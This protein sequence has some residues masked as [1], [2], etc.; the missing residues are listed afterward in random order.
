VCTEGAPEMIDQTAREE[1]L[2]AKVLPASRPSRRPPARGVALDRGVFVRPIAHR[3][4]HNKSRGLIENTAPAFLAAIDQDYG[5][6]CDLQPAR[7]GTPMVFHD[8]TLDRLIRGRGRIAAHTPDELSRLRYKDQDIA[9]LSFQDLLKLVAG[10]VPLLVEIKSNGR[11]PKRFLAAIAEGA[12]GYQGPIALMSFDRAVVTQLSRL[13]PDVPRGIV[14][15]SH[16][17]AG[18]W[19]A[20]PS[21]AGQN[22]AVAALLNK[23]PPELGFFAVEVRLLEPAKAWLA[24]HAPGAVLF[25]W[26]VRTAKERAAAARWADAPIFEA[27]GGAAM[28]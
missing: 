28:S 23:A 2:M 27:G 10:R 1:V 13:A 20:G 26:T 16:Q 9:I 3:G 5:I 11:M 6:E 18:N 21:A 8:A 22:A 7:D 4:L 12:V 15:G 14:V 19:W 25:T 24:E 17:L